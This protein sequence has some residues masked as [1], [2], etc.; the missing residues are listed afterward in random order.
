MERERE[1]ERR[2]V[3]VI[4]GYEIEEREHRCHR[5]YV[6]WAPDGSFNRAHSLEEAVELVHVI[7]R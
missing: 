7:D 2:I 1:M 3:R 6:I 5:Y 4:R